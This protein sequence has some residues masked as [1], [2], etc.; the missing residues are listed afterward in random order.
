MSE[1]WRPVVGLE[2]A[3]EVSSAGRVRTVERRVRFVSV[4]GRE[5]W[6]V[7]ASRILK[8]HPGTHGYLMVSLYKDHVRHARTVHSLVA[9]AFI[10]PRPVGADACHYD[11]VKTNNDVSNLRYD[12]RSANHKDRRRHKTVYPP[13][14]FKLSVAAAARI[15]SLAGKVRVAELAAEYGVVPNTIY[16]AIHKETWRYDG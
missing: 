16:R 8:T 11:G 5:A 2:D 4:R 12:T 1:V 15:R 6:R 7:K 14:Q 9:E 3:F 13:G 10:S